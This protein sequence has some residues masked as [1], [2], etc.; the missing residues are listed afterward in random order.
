MNKGKEDA[1]LGIAEVCVAR[2]YRGRGFV[3][4]MLKQL[5]QDFPNFNYAILLGD[6]GVYSS[7]GYKTVSNVYFPDVSTKANEDVMVK[8]FN[9]FTWPT[10]I[11][12]IKGMS[13]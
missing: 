10:G 6:K 4:A 11:I 3:K 5:E 1:F 2:T 9:N 13:F 12:E 7:S 8:C